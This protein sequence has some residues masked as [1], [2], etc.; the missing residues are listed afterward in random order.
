M[1]PMLIYVLVV[2]LVA[3]LIRHIDSIDDNDSIK[4]WIKSLFI[5]VVVGFFFYDYVGGGLWLV[6]FSAFFGD[7]W[8]GILLERFRPS[9][10]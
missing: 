5:A 4:Q 1:S 7:Y 6:F 10:E 2:S 8:F 9:G 3:G